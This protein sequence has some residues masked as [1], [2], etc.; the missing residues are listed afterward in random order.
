MI[1]VEENI[2]K[3]AANGVEMAT[4]ALVLDIRSGWSW[5][6]PSA[7]GEAP[8]IKTGNLD[9]SVK[10]DPQKRDT[11]GRFSADAHVMFVRIDT[12]EGVDP[13][14][15]GNYAPALEDESYLNRPFVQPAVDRMQEIFPEIMK[16]MI[17]P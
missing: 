12:S 11:S 1:R 10:I 3:G 14:G 9:S 5:S 2:D 8:A 17:K 15:R 6:S 7:E 4:Q 13:Q 16:R